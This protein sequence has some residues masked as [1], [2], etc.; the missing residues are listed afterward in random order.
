LG[1]TDQSG[2]VTLISF[3]PEV[4][5]FESVDS[6]NSELIRRCA[7]GNILA[8]TVVVA[9]EQTAG[10]GRLDRNWQSEPGSGLWCSVLVNLSGCHSP[11]WLPLIAGLAVFD[12]CS[13]L[14]AA[15]ELKWPNDV[16]AGGAKLGGI[17]IES[18]GVPDQWVV[19]IGINVT[20]AHF[21]NST[22]LAAL[23]LQ[24]PDIQNVLIA[25]L[26]SLHAHVE[27]WRSANWNSAE[28]SSRYQR[29]CS[30]IGATLRVSRPNEEPF[31]A[32]GLGID[33]SGHLVI[34]RSQSKPEIVVAAD[35]IHVTIESCTLKNS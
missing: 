18:S 34:A 8:W 15:V 24:P 10:R 21:P 11:T 25:V 16:T 28:L 22:A 12:A 2:P 30:S 35:V 33:E 13:G 4:I 23:C 20:V 29:E 9:S 3:C 14:G 31:N 26:H 27:S 17:L 7:G 19:G 32:Q 5:S 6:T 1:Q